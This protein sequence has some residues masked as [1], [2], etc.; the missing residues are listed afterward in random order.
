MSEVPAPTKRKHK[1]RKWA[2]G[3]HGRHQPWQHHDPALVMG[4]RGQHP[5]ILE[6]RT[7]FP[8]TVVDASA[9][10]RVLVSGV[11]SRKI[12]ARVT[13]GR[14]KGMPIY[15]L[16]LQE[17]ATCPTSCAVWVTCYGNNMHYA[18]RHNPG[19]E[20]EDKIIRDV[21]MLSRKHT[22]GIVI[23]LHVLGDFYSP[24]YVRMW[25]SLVLAYPQLHIFGFTAH[26][27][28]S[29]IG[30]EVAHLN[31][32]SAGHCVIRFSKGLIE[33]KFAFPTAETIHYDP[34]SNT[35]NGGVICPVQTNKTPACATCGLCWTTAKP[36]VFLL[37]GRAKK[38]A[39]PT[40]AP[41]G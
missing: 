15:T 20:L 14:W 33:D 29:E 18:R 19:P 10:P 24:E 16:T 1:P 35:H 25:L 4:L 6:S 8:S 39:T 23:R 3:A 9:S 13:K 31:D 37:H 30:A 27:S 40:N 26:P 36:I 12:G 21:T 7:L 34:K 28:T 2:K 38:N 11:N 32:L 22:L 41:S 17:R 5:A